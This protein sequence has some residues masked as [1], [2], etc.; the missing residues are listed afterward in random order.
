MRHISLAQGGLELSEIGIGS[1]NWGEQ[2]DERE[3]HRQLDWALARGITFVETAE[4]YPAPARAP[5]QGD[6][7]R[8]IGNWFGAHAGRRRRMVVATKIR[9]PGDGEWIRSDE[10][11]VS[12]S[13]VR[14]AI[15]DSL[16]RL[17]TDYVDLYQIH[18][19]E[20]Y[21]P[22]FGEWRFD[23]TRDRTSVSILEQIEAMAEAISAGKIRAYGLSN[24][25]TYGVCEFVHVAAAN[26]LPPPASIQN[27][28]N[29]VARLADGDLAE[30][31]FRHAVP[32]IAYGV[33]AKGL[34]SDKFRQGGLP[35]G[36]RMVKF[37]R[38]NERYMRPAVRHAA[39]AYGAIAD[40]HGMPLA[41]MALA[42]VRSRPFVQSTLI[43]GTSVKQLDELAQYFDVTLPEDCLAEIDAVHG[44]CPSPAA[45]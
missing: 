26:G 21:V 20:R 9:G 33:L 11:H 36:S 34:L 35:R 23:A 32:F 42:F 40:K 41:G 8:I 12:K 7:E 43:G 14:R 6:T 44:N 3:A 13:A 4:L 22:N 15:D 28:Y 19:P 16:K 27:G 45:Q 37:P 10:P 31:V 17:K 30:A 39:D 29:L 25:S 5:T 1:Q 18:W 24:E 2:S 38:P